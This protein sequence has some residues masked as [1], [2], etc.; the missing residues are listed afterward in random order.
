MKII[1]IGAVESTKLSFEALVDAGL[2]PS[3]LVTLHPRLAS[4]HSDFV[5]LNALAASAGTEVIHCNNINDAET[6]AD[7]KAIEPDL[8]L[9]LGWSQICREE[10]RSIPRLGS[11][12]FHPA[13]LPKM[14]GRAVIP[15][16]ILE[17]VK[18]TAA[19]LFWID[20]GMDSGDIIGQRIVRLSPDETARSLYDKQTSALAEMLPEVVK[21][22]LD[23]T[24]K[25]QPQDHSQAS[26]C[27]KRTPEDGR[28]DWTDTAANIERFI[29][30]VGAPYPGA[31]CDFGE[32]DRLWIDS[33][34]LAA[35]TPEY[36]GITGQI[37]AKTDGG[38]LILCGDRK[39]I[40]VLEWRSK[41]GKP[42][43]QHEVLGR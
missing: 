31:F 14:R 35:P 30:A 11:I 20:A 1:L 12:G 4:R 26:Y 29:R 22:S 5:D 6:L 32:D 9:V 2:T 15:W 37:Q 13:P 16:T 3:H 28:I 42:P 18:E 27:A 10:F 34:R 19:T 41:S 36:I 21:S 38:F 24:L 17:D 33:A 43:R 8:C 39:C 7:L 23:G 40:E 25:P